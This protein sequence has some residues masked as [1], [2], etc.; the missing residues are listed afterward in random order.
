MSGNRKDWNFLRRVMFAL[1]GL[2]TAF[3]RERNLKIQMM[4]G[5]IVIIGAIVIR[6]S[7]TDFMIILILIGGVVSL[8]LVNTA[9]EYAV[10]LTTEEWHPLAKAAK[11][12]AAGAILWFSV[13]SA[14]IGFMILYRTL[15]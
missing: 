3:R 14:I 9:I 4:A 2:L 1:S 6:V 11:D 10:D 12:I 5:L 7:Y 13:I 15:T 8:E